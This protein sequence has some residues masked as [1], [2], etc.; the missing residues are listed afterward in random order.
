MT[1]AFLEGIVPIL[2]TPFDSQGRIDDD[3]LRSLV[4]FNL[5]AGV[6]GLGIAI[7]SEIHKLSAPERDHVLD[8]VV[9]AVNGRVPVVM[10]VSAAGTDMAV[11]QA[12]RAKELGADA[13]MAF[14]PSFLPTGAEAVV[15]YFTRIGSGAKLSIVLQDVPQ[16]PISPDMA[17]RLADRIPDICAIKVETLPTVT[18]V[19]T[20][21]LRVDQSMLV[22]GGA[23]GSYMIEEFRRGARGT[24]P[25]CSQPEDFLAVWSALLTGDEAA[26]RDLFDRR[27]MAV[28]RLAAQGGDLFYHLHKAILVK[29]GVIATPFVR[30]PTASPDSIARAEIEAL[31]D[32]YFG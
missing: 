7:G 13:L 20:M 3:S 30:G 21:V 29:R 4:E 14:P 15:D 9:K 2:V 11:Q 17:L 24:M 31:V 23:G 5:E 10:N 19:Q 12:M 8:I 18:Q 27:I 26:A 6:H 28:N 32:Q 22:I 16:G 25:F 1:Q